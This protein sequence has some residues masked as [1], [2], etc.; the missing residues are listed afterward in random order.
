MAHHLPVSSSSAL[1]EGTQ[2]P[3]LLQKEGGIVSSLVAEQALKHLR[4]YAALF[5]SFTETRRSEL[6]LIV[7]VQEFCYE[8]INFMKV[9]Q[10]I[11]LLFYKTNVLSED[12][13]IKWYN[14][15]HSV[16]GK[17]IFLQ[18]ITKFIEWLQSA[19]EE[20]E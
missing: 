16:R 6:V 11:V 18:Q 17:S 19:E 13:I 10:K 4:Q 9:F 12:T 5:A 3:E 15:A 7:R 1:T 14:E 2:T 8:N 20:S